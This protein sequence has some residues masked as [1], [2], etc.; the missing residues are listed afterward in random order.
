MNR[1]IRLIAFIIING[2]FLY[3]Q[4]DEL[5]KPKLVI[6]IVVDQMRF[7]QL[8]KYQEKY[9]DGGFKRIM[10]EGFN[11]KNAHYNY[12]PTVTASGHASIY[13]G[14]TPAVH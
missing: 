8:Y 13:T 7:D 3:S 6:G 1:L 5:N 14:T 9:G 12:I 4:V 2:N 10:K 11:F